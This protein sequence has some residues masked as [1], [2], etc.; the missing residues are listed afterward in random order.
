MTAALLAAASIL[1]APSRAAAPDGNVEWA[2]I[3]HLPTMD[4]RPLCPVDG[5]AFD[6]LFQT[7]AN[8]LTGA[9]VRVDD[10]VPLWVTASRISVRGPYDVW[11]AS[12]PATAESRLTYYVELT[13]GGDVDYLGTGGLSDGPPSGSE[14]EVDFGTLDHAPVGATLLPGGGAIFKVWSPSRS[15]VHVRGEFNGWGLG[16]PMSKV[17]DHFIGRV[18]GASDRQMYKFYF[19][20]SH[21]NTDARARA[22]AP[23][24]NYNAIIEDPFRYAWLS[25]GFTPPPFEEMVI[26]QL[27]VG[28]FAGRNDPYG[29]TPFPSRYQDVALRASHL[30]ELGVNAVMLNPITEFP[31]DY[32]AG[33]NPIT[34]WAPESVYGD[35]DDLKAMI[36]ALHA[37]GIA[38]LLDIVWNHFSYSDNF[39]WQYDG[40]QLYF[41][42]PA[43]ETPW[44]S[45]ADFDAD[46]VRDY[47][48]ES[49]LL[50]LEEYGLDG[51]RMDATGY[52]NIDPQAASGWS[53]MQRLND[54]MNGRCV[55][56]IAI[57]EQLPDN[58]WVTRPTSLGG[59]GFDSQYHD[60]FTDRLREELFDAAFGD[61]EI[62]KITD[63][64]DGSGPYLEQGYVTNYL[65]LHDEAWPSSGGQRMVKSIDGT[66]P[67]D[68]SWAKGRTKLGQGLVMT[69]P[70]IP[71]ILQGTE[72]LED[73]DFGTDAGNR[74]DWSKR[75][76]YAGI[77]DY[78]R[79]LIALRIGNPALRADAG[80][81]IFH[82][83][84][85]ANVIG[86]QRFGGGEVLVVAANFGNSDRASYRIGLPQPGE[87][88]EALN[89]QAPEYE[90][91]GP[92]NP[93]TIT[94]ESVAYDGYAQS[95]AISIPKAG[96]V[97]LRSGS[98][99]SVGEAAPRG[100][101]ILRA[102]PNP[103]NPRTTIAFSLPAGG[104][105]RVRIHD[106]AGRVV[107]TLADRTF[108]DGV[109][110]VT[111]DG[112]GDRG[113]A[114][115]SGV[116]LVILETPGG[117]RRTSKIVLL[118]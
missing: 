15:T 92:T 86:F 57:A 14:F 19:E 29:T 39:L 18:P 73:S 48:V 40:T 8:D 106:L 115:A 75:T 24:D 25:E 117:T 9:R 7:Y 62:W 63:I 21:W 38:V 61:P 109:H 77:F 13:D 101:R 45:Q 44:G 76:T 2:G 52:M 33:Y 54:A 55:Q 88:Y 102:S 47:Y 49:A 5:E 84:E 93:G 53:L 12:I 94:A 111:W 27:H 66:F 78:Y 108:A 6:V 87:W 23:G 103:F 36:D 112:R 3:S 72:W 116:Y 41:D 85:A 4:R 22:L 98:L 104:R 91:T 11:S 95:A 51:F 113:N 89:S 80:L 65:E 50:W 42:D 37:E 114:A 32:S 100:A 16:N 17:G 96:L 105:A 79:D 70:G 64:V 97:I 60:A 110:T 28:T 46:G 82:T 56:K 118:R 58:S 43:V 59:A 26:Y 90:G 67:H 69:A 31:W 20:G 71:A 74:I 34:S 1:H 83:N 99:T 107:R 68:D 81:Q 10:G 35:P 30:A